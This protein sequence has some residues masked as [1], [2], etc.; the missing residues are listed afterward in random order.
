M[1]AAFMRA[2][3]VLGLFGLQGITLLIIY[4]VSAVVAVPVAWFL[5]KTILQGET[6]PF[7]MEMPP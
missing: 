1:L 6:P 3:L 2:K 7:V 4:I 5:K